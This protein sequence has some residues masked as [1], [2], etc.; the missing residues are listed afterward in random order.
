EMNGFL[1]Q[2]SH[3]FEEIKVK[4]EDNKFYSEDENEFNDESDNEF[5]SENE[6]EIEED[7]KT[8]FNKGE[9]VIFISNE[10][11]KMLEQDYIT[12]K[13][14]LNTAQEIAKCLGFAVTIKNSSCRHLHLQCKHGS[15]PC[16][17]SNLT[18][19]TRK[20]KRMS[21]RY[22][23]QFLLKAVLQNS[24]WH[25]TEIINKHNHPMTKD[26][27]IFHEHRQLMQETRS[28]AVRMLKAGAS[29]S[30]IYEAIRDEDGNPTTTR[31]DIS[32]LGLQI[33]SLEETA[34]MKALII[35]MKKRGY[36]VRCENYKG[37]VDSHLKHLFFCYSN[38]VT[39][40]RRFP[41]VVLI[42][43]T[44]KTNVY[45]LPFV[46]FV[47]I[48][49][50]GINK[51]QTFGIAGTWISDESENSYIWVIRQLISLVFFEL[52]PL[53]FVTDNDATLTSAV[54]K[55]FSKA[56]CLLCTWH[57]L[58]NF[59]KNLRK[60][61]DDDSFDEIIKTVDHLIN[62]RDYDAFNSTITAYKKLA[63]LSLNEENVIKY[64][65]RWLRL[66]YEE[67]SL[68][69]ESKSINIDPLLAQDDKYQLGPLL[70]KVSQFA[71]NS[72]KN[73]LLSTTIYEVCLCE[74]RVNY[75]IPCR[76]MLPAKCPI[77]LS[78]I[79]KR[80]LLFPD[81]DQLDSHEQ[82]KLVLLNQ[83]D[84]ILTVPEVKLSDI[85]NVK[86][87]PT[88]STSFSQCI[89]ELHIEASKILLNYH[90]PAD[91]IDQVYNPLSDGNCGFHA[92]VFAIRG[93]EENWD[94]IKL[95]M[96]NQL[97]KRMEIYK[98][99]LGY[100][101]ELL[102]QILES[103]ASPCEPSL[104]FLSPDCAQLAANTFSV[105]IAIFDERNEQSMMFFPLET[106]P[107]H[108]RNPIILHFINENHI[109]YV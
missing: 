78:S 38:S 94:L 90:I 19:D 85:K 71:L 82:Q 104:W 6:S 58:N 20:R 72:I 101:I 7:D 25:V 55:I 51:L 36:I 50:L 22:G 56:D 2:D 28:V 79:S 91:D 59:K 44:Y 45:K 108:R 97:N 53:V 13:D 35:G 32:N 87:E 5:G 18:V 8:R 88:K 64:L 106:P 3:N 76:H 100:N 39:S 26:E 30:M 63:S 80:W 14:I 69:Y 102:K 70:G 74:P 93:N 84:D 66:H 29:P 49:N 27:R 57:I 109:I 60:H 68:Q 96:N 47:G 73:E 65:E 67:S 40:A 10:I 17:T 16:N 95:A 83:L 75:N 34:S 46:N 86:K 52:S 24:K 9:T 31:K 105:P 81:Q 54:R 77:V 98:D 107:V 4:F 33:N 62:V 92:L 99:W 103:R 1:D 37:N 21:K 23:C 41:E 11:N 89:S 43:A 48:G 12:A 61:F 42:D 15:Q